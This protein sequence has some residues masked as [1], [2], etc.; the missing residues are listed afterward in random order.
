MTGAAGRLQN[1][2]ATSNE[3]A[4]FCYHMPTSTYRLSDDHDLRRRRHKLFGGIT[5]RHTAL[6]D[7]T[8][9]PDALAEYFDWL[10]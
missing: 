3:I 4:L 1:L 2:N 10:P 7:A 6:S 8:R 5:D 9:F